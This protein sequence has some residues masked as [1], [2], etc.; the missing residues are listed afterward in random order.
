MEKLKPKLVSL[1][2]ISLVA[3]ACGEAPPT[4]R[5]GTQSLDRLASAKARQDY[6]AK[7]AS[8][9]A[10]SMAGMCAEVMRASEEAH[11]ILDRSNPTRLVVDQAIWPRL[12][13]EAQVQ[14][15]RC[16]E[17]LRPEGSRQGSMTVVGQ[18]GA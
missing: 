5:P 8:G 2:M 6:F 7:A 15:R 1:A 13:L 12:P 9:S 16:A 17:D 14:I 18:P 3:A 4:V 11:L 10:A